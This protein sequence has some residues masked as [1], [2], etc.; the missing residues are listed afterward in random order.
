MLLSALGASAA[1]SQQAPGFEQRS[2]RSASPLSLG[3]DS[4]TALHQSLDGMIWVGTLGGGAYRISPDWQ[5]TE[6]FRYRPGDPA[7]LPSDEIWAIAEDTQGVL[8]IAATGGLCRYV[9]PGFRCSALHGPPVRPAILAIAPAGDNRLWVAHRRLGAIGFRPSTGEFGPLINAPELR[10]L[11]DG[12]STLF[13]DRERSELWFGRNLLFRVPVN[14]SGAALPPRLV[15]RSGPVYQLYRDRQGTL[16]MGSAQGLSRWEDSSSSFRPITAPELQS[17]AVYSI[18]A[19]PMGTLWLGTA[20]GVVHYSQTQGLARRFASG[21]VGTEQ[22]RGAALLRRDGAVLFGSSQGIT[23]LDPGIATGAADSARVV[24]T[25]W[26]RLTAKGSIEDS[27]AGA[28]PLRLEP[29]DRA[30]ALEFQVAGSAPDS[31]RR[32]RYRLEELGAWIETTTG[33]AT[34]GA[35]R[36]GR[37][38]FQVQASTGSVGRWTPAAAVPIQVIPRLW[39]TS[40]FRASLILLLAGLAWAAHRWR[41]KRALAR[42][43]LRLRLERPQ[44][45]ASPTA[46]GPALLSEGVASQIHEVVAIPPDQERVPQ[47]ESTRDKVS[48][49]E[50]VAATA[51]PGT[52]VSVE[53][54]SDDLMDRLGSEAQGALLQLCQEVLENVGKYA[55]AREVRIALRARNGRVDLSVTDDGVG[56]TPAGTYPGTGLK[57]LK[58]RAENLGGRIEFQCEPGHGTT[59]TISLPSEA[60]G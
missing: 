50:E 12:V 40:W 27:L 20:Q 39:S 36:P 57:R 55:Q 49:L 52:R 6:V 30:I 16:W 54:P 7:S 59:A 2:S 4:I 32:Y 41:L 5:R 11:T 31:G 29:G 13:F 43:R 35:L 48:R 44:L 28:R 21:F 51:L 26:R 22:S 34:F 23:K 60:V 25:R 9:G 37:Y 24:V 10:N 1:R 56:F 18:V 15:H 53:E 45:E 47:A 38:T 33:V 42:E 19:D 14:D 3:S 46:G 8:W 17:T 58:E